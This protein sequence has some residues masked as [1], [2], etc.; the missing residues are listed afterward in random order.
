MRP[1]DKLVLSVGVHDCFCRSR[2]FDVMLANV[3]I[4]RNFAIVHMQECKIIIKNRNLRTFHSASMQKKIKIYFNRFFIRLLKH[5]IQIFLT[6]YQCV[7]ILVFFIP[8]I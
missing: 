3:D 7:E 1:T 5:T 2:N 6:K 4:K 8:E